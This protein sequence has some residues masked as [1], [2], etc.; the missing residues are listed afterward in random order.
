MMRSFNETVKA[1]AAS[2]TANAAK[3]EA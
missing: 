3:A 1:G 2:K